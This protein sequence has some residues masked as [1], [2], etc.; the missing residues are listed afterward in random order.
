MIQ[1][2]HSR[3]TYLKKIKTPI[4]KYTWTPIFVPH[5]LNNQDME[6]I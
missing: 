3:Y 2:F 6:A 1:Q 4:Q 5:Y